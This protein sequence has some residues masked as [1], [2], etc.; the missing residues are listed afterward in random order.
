MLD[1]VDA[2]TFT[3]TGKD[4]QFFNLATLA[5]YVAAGYTKITIT[6]KYTSGQLWIGNNV[7]SGEGAGMQG[8]NNGDTKVVDI[9][10]LAKFVVYCSGAVADAEITYTFSK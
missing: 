4:G 7:W 6:A 8:L 3:F 9:T 1:K 5:D 10:D 2:D